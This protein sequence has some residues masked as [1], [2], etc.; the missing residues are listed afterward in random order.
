MVHVFHQILTE[1]EMELMKQS[2][3]GELNTATVEDT[4]VREGGGKKM[5]NERTQASGWLWDQQDTVLYKMA[6]KTAGFTG[7]EC[8]RPREMMRP[9][10]GWDFVE[11]EA[12]Q[13]GLYSPGELARLRLKQMS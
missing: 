5:S 1:G 2:A 11:A 13:I 12:W 6:L 4:A 3:M 8:A 7:L 9:G 10:L